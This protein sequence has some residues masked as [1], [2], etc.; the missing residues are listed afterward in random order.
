MNFL[1]SLFKPN[2]QQG[3]QQQQ[4]QQQQQLPQ[5]Q[6]QQINPMPQGYNMNN[7]NMNA[8]PMQQQQMQ[9]SS[10]A[11][12]FRLLQFGAK[13]AALSTTDEPPKE[14]K[15]AAVI[16]TICDGS[17]YDA[18]FSSV[19]QDSGEGSR[20]A[21]YQ[22]ACSDI[23]DLVK[24]SD[25]S[26]I[27]NTDDSDSDVNK[28]SD[29]LKQLLSDL[30]AIDDPSCVAVNYECCS[31]CN[32]HGFSMDN[33]T[34][35]Q[36][37]MFF[38]RKGFLVMYS[39][40]SL[41]AVI[42]AWQELGDETALGPLP[43]VRSGDWSNTVKLHFNPYTLKECISSQLQSVGELCNT[44]DF[45]TVQCMGGTVRY[46]VKEKF[47]NAN[48]RK[49]NP[50]FPWLMEILT[51][52]DFERHPNSCSIEV[53][54]FSKLPKKE[55]D[56]NSKNKAPAVIKEDEENDND[57][58][59]AKG[60]ETMDADEKADIDATQ[61]PMIM[62]WGDA[63]HVV[64]DFGHDEE[65]EEEDV[66]EGQNV[67]EQKA[68]DGND[69]T[70]EGQ[71]DEKPKNTADD[72]AVDETQT[73]QQ[74][75]KDGLRGKILFSMTH[76]CELV[77]LGDQ[78]NDDTLFKVAAKNLGVNSTAYQ[79]MECEYMSMGGKGATGAQLQEQRSWIT[80]KANIMVQQQAPCNNMMNSNYSKASK[81]KSMKY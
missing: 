48:F 35:M 79:Q 74:K 19:E 73:E 62:L 39:D 32:D 47:L 54:D 42:K 60:K 9:M 57:D 70:Q 45:C 66:D 31:G 14:L 75:S 1:G 59:K 28:R 30:S 68:N 17:T 49:E 71:P 33:A 58:D 67:S 63:G 41:K 16:I 77:K 15:L 37:L 8:I 18:L 5:L 46:S 29:D 53:P 69:V 13:P 10:E 4:Q 55:K 7:M 27:N 21:V 78:I 72:N 25:A 44:Q 20:V 76:W 51:I 64:L 61:L 34:V 6:Q 81:F 26:D 22:C 56:A 65:E 38:L 3:Q 50:T 11:N 43:L 23:A 36:Q 40:F 2:Q 80:K 24:Y 52:A 12:G